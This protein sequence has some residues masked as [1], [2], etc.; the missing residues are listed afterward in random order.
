MGWEIR[1]A[2][3]T[4]SVAI[5]DLARTAFGGAQGWEI[6]ELVAALLADPTAEP[7]VSLV[8]EHNATLVGHGLYTRAAVKGDGAQVPAAI[9][10]PLAVLPTHQSQGIGAALIA[11]GV[12]RLEATDAALLFVLGHPGYYARHAFRPAG[13][14]GLQAPYPIAPEQ[15]DAWMVR[16]LRPGFIGRLKGRVGCAEALM[17]PRHWQE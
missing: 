17:E 4:D 6:A 8:A 1:A 2:R 5:G 10:A 14:E 7:R 15:A 12:T 16:P 11:E 3:P 9:L 13:A